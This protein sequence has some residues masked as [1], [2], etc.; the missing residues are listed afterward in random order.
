MRAWL[1]RR[2]GSIDDYVSPNRNDYMGYM[3]TRQ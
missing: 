3:S 2:G 1:E